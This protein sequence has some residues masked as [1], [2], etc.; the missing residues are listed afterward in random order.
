LYVIPLCH[1]INPYGFIGKF[2]GY[3]IARLAYATIAETVAKLLA[4]H[5]ATAQIMSRVLVSRFEQ[6]RSWEGAKNNMSK[7]EFCTV[8]D[9]ELLTRIETATRTNEQIN[10]ARG[11]PE[12]VT[13]LLK[14]SRST[15]GA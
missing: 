4:K 9:E 2:Q 3:Q 13:T 5:H 7:L 15:T 10:S 1:G 11:V 6:S 12:R 14:K 8:F